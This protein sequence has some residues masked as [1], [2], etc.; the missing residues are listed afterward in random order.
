MTPE[1]PS[2]G[3]ENSLR[4]NRA[5]QHL[6][7]CI[8]GRGW[9]SSRRIR[10]C[11][12]SCLVAA[13]LTDFG[14]FKC[15]SWRRCD[16]HRG[17][18]AVSLARRRRAGVP[19]PRNP[20][21]QRTLLRMCHELRRM[22]AVSATDADARPSWNCDA[23]VGARLSRVLP[24]GTFGT[25]WLVQAASI[26]TC[27]WRRG[28]LEEVGFGRPRRGRPSRWGSHAERDRVLD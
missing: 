5:R 7:T 21:I 22:H 18:A 16:N 10:D 26:R 17:G 8:C 15:W 6:S 14:R 24:H 12:A 23:L 2:R 11:I 13:I 25:L 4:P 3:G 28:R 19:S 20:A 9:M 27:V 1:N